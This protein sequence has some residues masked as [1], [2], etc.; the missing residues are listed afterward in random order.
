[1]GLLSKYLLDTYYLVLA[2]IIM[3]N[4]DTVVDKK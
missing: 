2:L 1:M 4:G 3:S